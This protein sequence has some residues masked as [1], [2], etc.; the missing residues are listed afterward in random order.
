MLSCSEI[1]LNW[2]LHYKFIHS[3]TNQ[4][5]NLSKQHLRYFHNTLL[6]RDTKAIILRQSYYSLLA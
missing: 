5:K 2:K 1:L 6:R 4:L 3:Q